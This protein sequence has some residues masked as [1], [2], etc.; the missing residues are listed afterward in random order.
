MSTED[1]DDQIETECPTCGALCLST[2]EGYEAIVPEEPL[3]PLTH[4]AVIDTK[5]RV[6][7]LPRPFRHHHVLRVMHDLG[8]KQAENRHERQ[9]FLDQTGKYFNRRDAEVR[10]FACN[11]VI[12][13]AMISSILTSEDLW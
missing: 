11:Q 4:V 8:A 13:G 9:G 6:W 12:G 10:A 1:D 7:S 2:G 5:S 3:A